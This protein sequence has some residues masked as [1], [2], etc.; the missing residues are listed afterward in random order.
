MI[1]EVKQ[2]CSTGKNLFDI[3]CDGQLIYKADSTWFPLFTDGTNKMHLTDLSDT[4]VYQTKYSLLENVSESMIPFKYVFTGSQTFMKFYVLDRAHRDIGT[5]YVEVS[6]VLDRKMCLEYHGR[7]IAGYRK[8]AGDKQYVSFYDGES[9]VGQ[10]T[11]SNK[12]VDNLDH[13]V[14]HFLDGFEEWIPMLA[15]FTIYYDFIYNNNS[16]ELQK[17]YEVKYTYSFD[18]NSS[19]YQDTFIRDNFS[20]AEEARMEELLKVTPMVG[21]MTLKT[22]W[23][24]F[25]VGWG[26]ALFIVAL[27]FALVV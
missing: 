26:V 24:I 6:G 20:E 1:L 4:M 12:V 9:Q 22:F 7:V 13:Y 14:L 5:F 11:K 2:T 25:G 17:S 10:L 21:G 15:F 3:I 18:K 27:I 16:G 19:K 8:E 23:I